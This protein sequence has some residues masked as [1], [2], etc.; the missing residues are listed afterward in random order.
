V[1]KPANRNPAKPTPNTKPALSARVAR[2]LAPKSPP[3]TRQAEMFFND[4]PDFFQTS[5]TTP[6]PDRL[7]LRYEA[8]MAENRDI[9][10]GARVLDIASHDGRWS[11]AALKT[12]AAHVVGIEAKQDL[13]DNAAV[14]FGKYGVD[15]ATHEFVCGDIFEVMAQ[16]TFDVDVVMCLG[17][18]YHTLRY[19]ELLSLIRRLNPKYLII[20]TVVTTLGGGPIVKLRAEAADREHNAVPDQHSYGNTVLSGKPNMKAM[21]VMLKA[22]GFTITKVSDWGSLLRDN[23]DSEAISTYARGERVTL[24]CDSE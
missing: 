24:R 10:Q 12:G 18:L 14:T 6:Q 4:Y 20:D 1:R 21:R 22:Y 23:P 5:R 8:I 19:N 9:L 3:G 16:Q 2:R 17:F 7:N 13:V 15:P 11:F